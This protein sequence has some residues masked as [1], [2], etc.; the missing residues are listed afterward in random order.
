MQ[1]SQFVF[2]ATFAA[3]HLFVKYDIP[4][5]TSYS[6]TH[7]I[8]SLLSTASSTAVAVA[9]TASSA[10]VAATP[11]Y[12][13]LLKRL[14]LR[15]AG[16][17]GVAE[18]VRDPVTGQPVLEGVKEAVERY[19]TETRGRTEYHTVN[20]IDTTG[21]AFAIWLNII[22]LLP[23]TALFVRFF[24][25]AYTSRGKGKGAKHSSGPHK[26]GRAAIEA[27]KGVERDVDEV[28]RAA[29]KGVNKVAGSIKNK[30]G[31][32]HRNLS[33][34]VKRD[35]QALKD[36]QAGS[37]KGS[38]DSRPSSSSAEK[39]SFSEQADDAVSEIKEEAKAIKDEVEDELAGDDEGLSDGEAEPERPNTSDSKASAVSTPSKKKKKNKKN[40]GGAA[41]STASLESSGGRGEKSSEVTAVTAVDDEVKDVGK[42]EAEQL[43]KRERLVDAEA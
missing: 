1:I 20:C 23:L 35:L 39:K 21:Q 26:T 10:V 40:K 38:T 33:E 41:D 15:A 7:P 27:A 42:K 32:K 13:A 11:T 22:Y 36:K 29:E 28:G 18:N 12:A 31:G 17:E 6:I 37:G 34:E 4:V 16:E 5:N 24:V 14:F 43:P 8:S 3:I 2:G 30:A 25:R 19:H 9:S